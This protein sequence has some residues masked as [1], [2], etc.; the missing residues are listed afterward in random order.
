[1]SEEG[2]VI[3]PE[4]CLV[5]VGFNMRTGGDDA[6]M[7]T[8]ELNQAGFA[9]F[10]TLVYCPDH[11]GE[12]WREKTTKGFQTCRVFI[13]LMTKGW[14]ESKECKWEFQRVIDRAVKE[15]VTIIPVMYEDFDDDLDSKNGDLK[16]QIGSIE[17]IFHSDSGWV[18]RVVKSVKHALKG[19]SAQPDPA[20]EGR[21]EDPTFTPLLAAVP[22]AAAAAESREKEVFEGH[23]QSA[24]RVRPCTAGIA[25]VINLLPRS[26]R[27]GKV[28][29]RIVLNDESSGQF[30]I[31]ANNLDESED[32]CQRIVLN[33]LDEKNGNN[34]ASYTIGPDGSLCLVGTD[35]KRKDKFKLDKEH[36]P[37]WVTDQALHLVSLKYNHD[38]RSICGWAQIV[39]ESGNWGSH[40]ANF[41]LLRVN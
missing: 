33:K 18:E 26:W 8:Q 41:T 2:V 19:T 38:T 3:S 22:A 17:F 4:E 13:P 16:I 6:K 14:Q 37:Q 21:P 30:T 32:G 35:K 9:T 36:N 15:E 34:A 29:L 23:I 27:G 1:M 25:A 12:N 11:G 20:V 28:P 40:L 31:S 24:V 7:L 10:C 39:S 5:M